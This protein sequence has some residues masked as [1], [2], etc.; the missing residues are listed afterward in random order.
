MV[1]RPTVRQSRTGN[2]R[3]RS[4]DAARCRRVFRRFSH[5]GLRNPSRRSYSLLGTRFLSLRAAQTPTNTTRLYM[6]E[7]KH[8]VRQSSASN[9]I[10]SSLFVRLKNTIRVNSS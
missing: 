1:Q 10:V 5:A 7:P 8:D 9:T 2:V 6:E 4:A 3:Y